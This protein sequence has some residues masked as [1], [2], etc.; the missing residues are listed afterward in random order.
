MTKAERKA[1]ADKMAALKA[2]A[3]AIVATGKCPECGT[4]LRQNLALAGWWQCDAFGEPRFRRPENRDKP[5]CHFQV[6]TE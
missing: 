6:F 3:Q 5:A 4:A 2:K 1:H